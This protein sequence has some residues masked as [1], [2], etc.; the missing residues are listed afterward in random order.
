M[1]VNK[2]TMTRK[3]TH[4]HIISVK[5]THDCCSKRNP[6]HIDMSSIV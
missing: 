3:N 4:H 6:E 1:K 2:K 5:T